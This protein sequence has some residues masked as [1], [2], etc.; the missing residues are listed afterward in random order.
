MKVLSYKHAMYKTM[1]IAKLLTFNWL[2][3]FLKLI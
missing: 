2:R 1:K 3:K